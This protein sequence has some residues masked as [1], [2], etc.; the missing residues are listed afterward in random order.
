MASS[1]VTPQ[2]ETLGDRHFSFYPPIIGVEHNEWTFGESNWSEIMVRNAKLDDEIW[3][4]R[5]YIGEVSK[6][7]EPV[8]IV[9]LKRELE[10]KGGLL[11]PHSRR[12]LTMPSNPVATAHREPGTE[13]KAESGLS[14]KA[15]MRSAGGTEGRV[16]KLI[17]I[18]LIVGIVLTGIGVLFLRQRTTGGAIEYKGVLQ[19]DL[20]L[21]AQS[22]YFDVVRKLGPPAGDRWRADAGERQ[23]RA[24]V[25]P[26][27]DLVIILMG[28]DRE[29]V[30]YIGAK[31]T[32]WRT[33]HAV[34]LA[35]NNKSNTEPI[36]RSLPKF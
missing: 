16:G 31:D 14:V 11:S 22:D 29:S 15:A 19:I 1:P 7:D 4:P 6:V 13:P 30:F 24:L 36:L 10:Y 17:G 2:L 18:A 26:K 28:A 3:I 32:Q 21:T 5:S 27:N 33:V 9:G 35:G 23:Y 12:V 25:Y 20:G 34:P 8:M